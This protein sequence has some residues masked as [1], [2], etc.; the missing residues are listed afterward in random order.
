[1]KLPA[2]LEKFIAT[3]VEQGRYRSRE[4]AIVAALANEKRRT[5]Q[6]AWLEAEL[7]RGLDSGSAGALSV[8]EVIRRGRTRRRSPHL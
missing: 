6:R 7:Q 2:K 5:E 4:A 1:V 3:Q 8:E